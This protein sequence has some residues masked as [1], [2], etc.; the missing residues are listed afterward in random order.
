MEA[1]DRR[2]QE[3]QRFGR[4][5][6]GN[7]VQQKLVM[8]VG[9]HIPAGHQHMKSL[10]ILVWQKDFDSQWDSNQYGFRRSVTTMSDVLFFKSFCIYPSCRSKYSAT[11]AEV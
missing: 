1:A 3:E 11:K 7:F 4:F 2:G 10:L 8:P 5:K 6:R 9:R